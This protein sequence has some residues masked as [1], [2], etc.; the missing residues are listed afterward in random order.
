[1][2]CKRGQ[3]TRSSHTWCATIIAHTALRRGT[4]R[5][6]LSP[7]IVLKRDTLRHNERRVRTKAHM[8]QLIHR[9]REHASAVH[10]RP[11]STSNMSHNGVPTPL[12]LA[13]NAGS[14]LWTHGPCLTHSQPECTGRGCSTSCSAAH[15]DTFDQVRRSEVP[16]VQK[17]AGSQ[18]PPR[19]LVST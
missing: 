13:P 18:T 12:V 11:V 4:S 3:T 19:D 10:A 2:R 7:R 15:A 5:S 1:M 16:H 8:Q 6:L 9:R 17:K 14:S